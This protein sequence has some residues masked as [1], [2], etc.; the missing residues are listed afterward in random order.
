M[1]PGGAGVNATEFENVRVATGAELGPKVGQVGSTPFTGEHAD[2]RR[3][4]INNPH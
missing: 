4:A 3:S 1:R 2:L